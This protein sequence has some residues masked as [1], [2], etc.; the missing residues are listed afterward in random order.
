MTMITLIHQQLKRLKEQGIILKN[1][2][3]YRIALSFRISNS[4]VQK[5]LTV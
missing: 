2:F 3:P 4:F 1:Q 5:I